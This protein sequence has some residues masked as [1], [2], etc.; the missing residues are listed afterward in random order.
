[1]IYAAYLYAYNKYI[2]CVK[3]TAIFPLGNAY[4]VLRFPDRWRVYR[5][6]L[7]YSRTS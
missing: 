5:A 3:L 6:A 7:V 2:E 4:V 1:M